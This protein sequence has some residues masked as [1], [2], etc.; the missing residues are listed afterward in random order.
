MKCKECESCY[1]GFFKSKPDKYVCIGVAEPFVISDINQECTEYPD[2]RKI[3]VVKSF[4]DSMPE[5]LS[6]EITK[7]EDG[8]YKII[9]YFDGKDVGKIE[10]TYP[11]VAIS[12]PGDITI[13]WNCDGIYID[14]LPFNAKAM[15]ADDGGK[16]VLFTMEVEE[17]SGKDTC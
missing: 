2:K 3:K 1:K 5:Y 11:R 9:H 4:A 8:S 17:A 7:N 6:S 12:I 14:P 13:K 16:K 15:S 10:I